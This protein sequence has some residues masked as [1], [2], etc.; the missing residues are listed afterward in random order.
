MRESKKCSGI[1]PRTCEEFIKIHFGS[2]SACPGKR[3]DANKVSKVMECM[4]R[5]Y[6]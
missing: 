6:E 3:F 5:L 1:K 2:I 4:R